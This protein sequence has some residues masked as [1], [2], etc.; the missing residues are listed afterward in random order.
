MAANIEELLPASVVEN[1]RT[2]A[3]AQ[4]V[5]LSDF[6]R[7]YLIRNAPAVA[8]QPATLSGDEWEKALDEFFD[9][10]PRV[11]PLSDDAFS[12]ENMYGREDTW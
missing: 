5:S 1:Y 7:D 4:G 6:V 8:S 3:A 11:G 12:R 9:S 10:F 2:N